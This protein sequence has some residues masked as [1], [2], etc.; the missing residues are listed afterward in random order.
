MT[1]RDAGWKKQILKRNVSICVPQMYC[2]K[3][4]IAEQEALN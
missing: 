4:K 3:K 2:V 1:N